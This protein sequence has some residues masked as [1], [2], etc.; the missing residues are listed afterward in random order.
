MLGRSTAATTTSVSVFEDRYFAFAPFEQP[1]DV[2]E[3]AAQNFQSF[4]LRFFGKRDRQIAKS[5]AALTMREMK[6]T[7]RE[8]L[9]CR[10]SERSWHEAKGFQQRVGHCIFDVLFQASAHSWYFHT[11]LAA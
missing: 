9:G 1:A 2:F 6:S 8:D 7:P 11:L 4:R 5:G 3:T 10:A